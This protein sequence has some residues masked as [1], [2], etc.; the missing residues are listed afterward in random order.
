M[1]IFKTCVSIDYKQVNAGW[2]TDR[3]VPRK[4]F[5]KYFAKILSIQTSDWT[6]E[7]I[8]AR[9]KFFKN[10]RVSKHLNRNLSKM[11]QKIRNYYFSEH[12]FKFAFV[13]YYL[14][15]NYNWDNV[16]KNGWSKICKGQPLKILNRYDPFNPL[17]A[18][19]STK[20]F[21]AIK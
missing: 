18:A 13:L 20:L 12:F 10:Y 7:E 15:L 1:D 21:F 17:K 6:H 5:M 16:F 11:F 14:L 19:S 4:I 3:L 9:W 2:D 8:I